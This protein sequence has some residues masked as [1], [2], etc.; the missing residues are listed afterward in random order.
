MAF[1]LKVT[2]DFGNKI[3]YFPD[4]SGEGNSDYFVKIREVTQGDVAAYRN[5]GKSIRYV[6]IQN[7]RFAQEQEFPQGDLMYARAEI[8]VAEWN[9]DALD[10]KGSTFIVPFS[11]VAWDQLPPEWAIWLDDVIT[12]ENPELIGGTKNRRKTS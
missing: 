9:L 1:K 3:H 8:C 12:D 7:E 6:P 5:L 4:L 11:R 10:D 2:S